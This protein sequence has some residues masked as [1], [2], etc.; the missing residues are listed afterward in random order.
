M[1]GIPCLLGT[2][3]D[4]TFLIRQIE[5]HFLANS[6][7]NIFCALL[8]DF[9]DAREKEMPGDEQSVTY[10]RNAIQQLNKKY[11][12]NDYQPF[13]FFHRKGLWNEGEDCCMG[14]ERKRGKLE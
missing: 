3:R 6:D 5:H 9:A 8:T 14:W 7:P 12:N 10:T 4:A 1:V 13:Y 2:E 11:G